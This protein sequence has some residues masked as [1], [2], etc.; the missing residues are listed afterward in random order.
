MRASVEAGVRLGDVGVAT[1]ARI[2][3]PT[4]DTN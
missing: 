4:P 1:L 3:A 2:D